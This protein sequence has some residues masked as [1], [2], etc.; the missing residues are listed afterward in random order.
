MNERK[1]QKAKKYCEE[2]EYRK[3]HPVPKKDL[4]DRIYFRFGD[5]GWLILQGAISFIFSLIIAVIITFIVIGILKGA[6]LR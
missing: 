5:L 3:N 1:Y 2:Y 4:I 6:G